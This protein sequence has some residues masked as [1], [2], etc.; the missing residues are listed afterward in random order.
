MNTDSIEVTTQCSNCGNRLTV[1]FPCYESR[2]EKAEARVK[3]LEAEK[4]E[5]RVLELEKE[6]ALYKNASSYPRFE[7]S[8]DR[9]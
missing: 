7:G 3:E 4:A 2:A 6:L 9:S 5:A 8:V 1:R